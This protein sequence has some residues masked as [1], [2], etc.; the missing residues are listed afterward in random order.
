MV[1]VCLI[2]KPLEGERRAI[3]PP[4][5]GEGIKGQLREET[6]SSGSSQVNAKANLSRSR[7]C[8][9]EGVP[10]KLII[11]I[12]SPRAFLYLKHCCQHL[13]WGWEAEARGGE[14]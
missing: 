5:N 11:P 12:L 13:Q 7:D 6:G 14:G 1:G 9:L 8:N 4:A 3:P 10:T 2:N